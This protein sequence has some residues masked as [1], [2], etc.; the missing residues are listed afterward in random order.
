MA[1]DFF[2]ALAGGMLGVLATGR[3]P[4][5]AWRFLRLVAILVFAILCVLTLAAARVDGR[6]SAWM[7]NP[8]LLI[9]GVATL[10]AA[11]LIA[12][13][14]T[15]A[16][17]PLTFRCICAATAIAA[18]AG[19]FDLIEA[20]PGRPATV[21]TALS[22]ILAA[23]LLG[24]ITVAW[25]LGHA[26]LTATR[27]SIAPLSHFTRVLSWAIV[28][29]GTFVVVSLLVAW[30]IS[31]G[32]S[33]GLLAHLKD[34]WLILILRI[35]VGLLLVGAFVYMVS[36]CVR[37]RSTQSATGILYF[38]SVFAYVGELA[39]LHLMAHYGWPL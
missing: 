17:R 21:M 26:Y 20:L 32:D 8:S 6:V 19:L 15:A 25:L 16:V 9:G 7:A 30:L 31:P 12:L 27:M 35:G 36:D 34:A 14:R 18:L 22:M 24:S 37:I 2:H 3:Y 33:A 23:A 13:S 38:G 1:T 29:R 11:I 28:L 4:Q 5:I 39:N 10:G